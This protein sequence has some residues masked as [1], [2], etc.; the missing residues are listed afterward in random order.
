[1]NGQHWTGARESIMDFPRCDEHREK[2][3]AFVGCVLIVAGLW[4][5]VRV[6]LPCV[7]G[8]ARLLTGNAPSLSVPLLPGMHYPAKRAESTRSLRLLP[9]PCRA[10]AHKVPASQAREVCAVDMGA[11]SASSLVYGASVPTHL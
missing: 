9:P 4:I 3:E 5:A 11:A 1:M 8:T 7:V 10:S 6:V 2:C